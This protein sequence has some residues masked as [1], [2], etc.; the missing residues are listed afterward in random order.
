MIASLLA[1]LSWAAML[2]AQSGGASSAASAAQS[3]S[4]P[5]ISAPTAGTQAETTNGSGPTAS[6]QHVAPMALKLTGAAGAA[7]NAG[8]AGPAAQAPSASDTGATLHLVVGR[9][10]FVTVPQKL[11]RVY[12]SNAAVLDAMT[13]SPQEVI[14]TAKSAGVSS[15]VLWTDA[16]SAKLFT[17]LADVDV[18]GLRDSLAAALPGDEV[19]VEAQQGRVHLSGVVESDAAA[20]EAGRLASVYSKDVVNSLVVDPRHLPQIQLQV[21]I[22]EIDR[23]KLDA[24]GINFFSL[25]KNSGAITTEQFSPPTFQTQNGVN[26]AVVS[27]YLNLFYFNFDHLLGA[28]IKD[29][30]TKGILEI[31]AEPT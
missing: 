11:R 25:G 14:L 8:N 30:Q 16:G 3:A 4:P 29:L 27:D 21:R 23:S 1:L 7:G 10:L 31:L 22:A 15:L 26:T 5:A 19:E 9:S 13:S 20:D 17:V 24:F 28:T 2:S 18:S 6:Q 12:V